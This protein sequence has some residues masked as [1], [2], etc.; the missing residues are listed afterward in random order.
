MGYLRCR[1]ARTLLARGDTDE[2]G[3]RYT[4]AL[5]LARGDSAAE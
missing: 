4:Q 5:A 2:A 1:M 3:W